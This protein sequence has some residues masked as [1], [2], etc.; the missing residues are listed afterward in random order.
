MN[1][2]AASSLLDRYGEP[3]LSHHVRDRVRLFAMDLDWAVCMFLILHAVKTLPSSK[4]VPLISNRTIQGPRCS[5]G[6]LP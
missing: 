4:D 5:A 2:I 1:F 6:S 3:R